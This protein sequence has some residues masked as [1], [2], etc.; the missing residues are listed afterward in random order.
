VTSPCQYLK[1][2][3]VTKMNWHKFTLLILILHL[4]KCTPSANL[5]SVQWKGKE[6]AKIGLLV[7]GV[8]WSQ[9]QEHTIRR[10]IEIGYCPDWSEID[11][12]LWASFIPGMSRMNWSWC[13][14]WAAMIPNCCSHLTVITKIKKLPPTGQHSWGS[15][16]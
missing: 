7:F 8:E 3:I 5:L 13:W 10:F 1:L 12:D 11:T 2:Y 15:K 6:H 14:L 16:I 9:P 4:D